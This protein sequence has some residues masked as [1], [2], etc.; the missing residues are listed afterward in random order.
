MIKVEAE[1]CAK[2]T[3][4]AI[5]K[6]SASGET[7]LSFIVSL[8]VKGRD[9]SKKDL[10][11]TVTRDGG[12]AEKLAFV[13]NRRVRIQGVMFIRKKSGNV[14]WNLRAK[15][16]D[17]ENSN[18]DDL[19]EGIMDFRGRVGKKGVEE[20]KNK[21]GETYKTFSAFSSEKDGESLEFM[22]VNFIYFDPKEGEDFLD[23]NRYVKIT[24]PLRLDIFRDGISLGCQVA[25]IEEWILEH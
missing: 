6:E 5:V 17:I 15:S 21:R 8:P 24:G 19:I 1:V 2:I 12:R 10:S 22:W 25:G 20:K 7:F 16:C 3:R 18:K 14:Y 11:I 4:S 9:G 23:A 13:E